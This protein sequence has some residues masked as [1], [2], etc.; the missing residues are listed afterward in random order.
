MPSIKKT[1]SIGNRSFVDNFWQVMQ[2]SLSWDYARKLEKQLKGEIKEL[3]HKAKQAYKEDLQEGM[4][5]PEELTR[6][7]SR[8]K[9][10]AAAKVQIEQRAA[11]RFAKEHQ[12]YEEKIAARQAIR[13]RGR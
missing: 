3:L 4:N 6:R 13:K 10:I 1:Y 2:R 9:A 11:E 5:I 12:A 8:F 7:K